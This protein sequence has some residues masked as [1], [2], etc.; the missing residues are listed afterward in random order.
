MKIRTGQFEA[1][2]AERKR[3]QIDGVIR[4]LREEIPEALAGVAEDELRVRTQYALQ[5]ALSFLGKQ[6]TAALGS[7]AAMLWV[8]L[9]FEVSPEFDRDPACQAVLD[10]VATPPQSRILSLLCESSEIDW[11]AVSLRCGR[12]WLKSG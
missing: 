1:L 11:S 5:R 9:M 3:R 7:E 12:S 4:I 2:Q 8:R 10:D 6:A